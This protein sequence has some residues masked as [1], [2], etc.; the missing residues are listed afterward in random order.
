VGELEP[1]I[2]LSRDGTRCVVTKAGGFGDSHSLLRVL[3][4]LGAEV[5]AGTKQ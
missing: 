2:C 4:H 5:S 3:R 1:G